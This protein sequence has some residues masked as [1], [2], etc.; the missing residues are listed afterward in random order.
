MTL[1]F[2]LYSGSA[3]RVGQ[4]HVVLS[5]GAFWCCSFQVV[6]HCHELDL[7]LL[8]AEAVMEIQSLRVPLSMKSESTLEP[9][10]Q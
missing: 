3:R 7:N 2:L 5:V 10:H 9:A 4:Q 8:P 1:G 6:T